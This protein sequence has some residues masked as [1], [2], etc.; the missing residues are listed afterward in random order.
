MDFFTISEIKCAVIIDYW[1]AIKVFVIY[2]EREV[3]NK[4]VKWIAVRRNAVF[5]ELTSAV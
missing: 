5:T 2:T 1:M 3:W 4:S